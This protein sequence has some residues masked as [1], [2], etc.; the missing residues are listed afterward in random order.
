MQRALQSAYSHSND[1]TKVRVKQLVYFDL[2]I[3]NHFVRRNNFVICSPWQ[4]KKIPQLADVGEADVDVNNQGVR[5]MSIIMG[6]VKKIPR[7]L[8]QYIPPMTILARLV[9]NISQRVLINNILYILGGLVK[10]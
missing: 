2:I 7:W 3:F 10:I 5:K 6:Q 4:R 1:S 9:V 8:K